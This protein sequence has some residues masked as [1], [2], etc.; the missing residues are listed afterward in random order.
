MKL[1]DVN[2]YIYAVTKLANQI[3]A[4]A[5]S[6]GH[7]CQAYG[8]SCASISCMPPPLKCLFKSIFCIVTNIFKVKKTAS[9]QMI[10]VV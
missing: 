10:E 4:K 5:P 8:P 3:V 7:S 1:L 2:E 6:A 9:S